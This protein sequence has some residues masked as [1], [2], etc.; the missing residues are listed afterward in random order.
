MHLNRM[1]QGDIR[2]YSFMY[3][4]AGILIPASLSV[5]LTISEGGFV[6]LER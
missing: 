6:T 2:G 3:G 4:A 5:V 1:V